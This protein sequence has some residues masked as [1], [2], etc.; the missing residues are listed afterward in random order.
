MKEANS[1]VAKWYDNRSI[2]VTGGSGF[3]GK[4]LVE[5]LLYSCTGI[6]CIY[7]LLRPKRGKLPDKRVEDMW[8]LPVDTLEIFNVNWSLKCNYGIHLDTWIIKS[9]LAG[10]IKNYHW[11]STLFIALEGEP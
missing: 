4:V 11:G 5:K 9:R 8:N 7:I 1:P 6:K 2:F 10:E 3:M